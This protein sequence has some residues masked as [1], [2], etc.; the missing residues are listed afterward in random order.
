M[1]FLILDEQEYMDFKKLAKRK[2]KARGMS[3]EDLAVL[4]GYTKRSLYNFFSRDNSKFIACAIAEALVI[5]KG[6]LK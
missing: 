1:Y 6:D 3:I 5:K 2:M 4:T